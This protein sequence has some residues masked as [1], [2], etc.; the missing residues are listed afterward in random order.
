MV[1]YYALMYKSGKMR[2]D[3]TILGEGG[4]K[5]NDGGNSTM[6]DCNTFVNVTVHPQCNNNVMMKREKSSSAAQCRHV[7]VF[8]GVMYTDKGIVEAHACA[9]SIWKLRQED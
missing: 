6:I 7:C 3:E 5:E 9:L 1:E 4:I 8:R 2:P